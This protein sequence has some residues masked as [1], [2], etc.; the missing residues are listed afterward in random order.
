MSTHRLESHDRLSLVLVEDNADA[1]DSFRMLLELYG[2]R[3]AL[4]ADGAAG[5]AVIARVAPDLAFVDIG[6][7]KLNGFEVAQRV[8]AGGGPQPVLIAL[9]GYGGLEDKRRASAAGFDGHLTKPVDPAH[10]LAIWRG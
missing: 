8:R 10:V 3:V 1:A 2:H 5:V 9:S 4:A 7:P 6:L